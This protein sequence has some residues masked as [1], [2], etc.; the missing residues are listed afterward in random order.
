MS[1]RATPPTG[2]SPNMTGGF[3]PDTAILAVA[4]VALEHQAE[5][6]RQQQ[7]DLTGR[8]GNDVTGQ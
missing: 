5:A 3:V 8:L 2:L 1:P 4:Q 6:P 7:H